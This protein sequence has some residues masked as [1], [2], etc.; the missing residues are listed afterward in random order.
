MF[1]GAMAQPLDERPQLFHTPGWLKQKGQGRGRPLASSQ[2][3][4]I[5]LPTKP[6]DGL[7]NPARPRGTW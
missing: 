7:G 2:M 1:F 6:I 5:M 4:G 3:S